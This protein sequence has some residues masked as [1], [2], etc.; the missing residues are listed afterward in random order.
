MVCPRTRRSNSGGGLGPTRRPCTAAWTPCSRAQTLPARAVC[1]AARART[2]M[3]GRG[4]GVR[5][6]TSGQAR[7]TPIPRI[8]CDLVVIGASVGSAR[9]VRGSLVRARARAFGGGP[10]PVCAVNRARARADLGGRA[11]PG[12]SPGHPEH[13]KMVAGGLSS[14]HRSPIRRSSVEPPED[15]ASQHLPGMPPWNSEP[16]TDS[17]VVGTSN[18]NHT[19]RVN[20]RVRLTSWL[21]PRPLG[22]WYN[23]EVD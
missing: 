6:Q 13:K 21:S 17:G 19:V 23:L 4:A 5:W 14:P 7:A 3:P 20:H 22:L 1:S 9:A 15:R 2:G 8:R 10:G 16:S 11:E 12:C 18:P